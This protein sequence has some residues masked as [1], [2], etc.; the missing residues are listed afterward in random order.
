MQFRPLPGT[1]YIY[2]MVN[3]KRKE[4]IGT[5]VLLLFC[6][7]IIIWGLTDRKQLEGRHELGLWYVYNISHGTVS[8]IYV[9]YITYV[10]GQY[11][12]GSTVFQ[13][14]EISLES[15]EK[16]L[17][18]KDLPVVYYPPRPT[19]SMLLIMPKDFRRFGYPFPDNLQ[20]LLQYLKNP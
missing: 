18:K 6:T 3:Y 16:Y 14:S 12:R 8:Q 11:Y 10:H 2:N 4:L 9:D 17:L 7:G 1:F 19:N 20:W 13:S 5:I 15:C